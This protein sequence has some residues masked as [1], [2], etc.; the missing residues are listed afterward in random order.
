MAA[1]SLP[2]PPLMLLHPL[3][4]PVLSGCYQEGE[5]INK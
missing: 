3:H 1:F 4:E 5:K 2:S